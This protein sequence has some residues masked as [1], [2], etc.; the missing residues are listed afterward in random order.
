[1]AV[2]EFPGMRRRAGGLKTAVAETRQLEP[3]FREA[4]DRDAL[5][6]SGLSSEVPDASASSLRGDQRYDETS[7]TCPR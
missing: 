1:M 5:V 6:L 3:L 4:L 2:A 7:V